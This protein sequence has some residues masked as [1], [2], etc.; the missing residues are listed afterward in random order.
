MSAMASHPGPLTGVR[1]VEVGGIGPVP[2]CGMVLADL[3]A[4]V[5]RV[6]RPGQE[7]LPGDPLLRGRRSSVDLKQPEGRRPGAGLRRPRPTC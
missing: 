4:A 5:T 7:E 3:G 2:F 1:V 6:I